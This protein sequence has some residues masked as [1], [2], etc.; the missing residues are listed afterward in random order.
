MS[1][2]KKE[3]PACIKSIVY[4]TLATLGVML[5]FS[6]IIAAVLSEIENRSIRDIALFVL[7]MGV[8]AAFLYRFRM[9]DRLDTYAEHTKDFDPK[10][11]LIA[12]IY[13]DGKIMFA[14]YG[15]IAVVTEI[16]F[17]V[18][19]YV[20]PDTPQN[21]IAFAAM[22]C[23]SPLISLK[24]PVLRSVLAFAYSAAVVCLLAVLRSRKI[25][26]DEA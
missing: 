1:K 6:I 9:Y 4:S 2:F 23:L 26:K 21:P 10:T 13:A 18:M 5:I 12:Y 8:Y 11:E 15:I 14:L 3:F 24:I 16:S 25:H 7:I 19:P 20:T 17:Y 22:L